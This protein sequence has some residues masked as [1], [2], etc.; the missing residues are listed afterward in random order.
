MLVHEQ[1]EKGY[2]SLLKNTQELK[3]VILKELKQVQIDPLASFNSFSSQSVLEKAKTRKAELEN[4]ALEDFI[5]LK[6]LTLI[7]LFIFLAAETVTV[8]V[9]AFFQGFKPREFIIE[10][11][12]FKLIILA[13]I[14]QITTMLLVAVKHLFP[15][16]K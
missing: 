6:R 7:L 12:S 3:S 10:E 8:F 4:D 15:Q 11:W 2:E 16:N 1:N 14:T 13:T 5:K 9:I